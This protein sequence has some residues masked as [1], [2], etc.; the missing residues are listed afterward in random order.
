MPD[1]VGFGWAL[2]ALL[3]SGAVAGIVTATAL[4]VKIPNE[5]RGVCLGAFVVVAAVIGFGV[6]PTV[7]SFGST[8]LGGESHL[9]Q[10]LAITGV[11]IDVLSAL[12]FLF[13]MLDLARR[14]D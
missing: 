11:A 9:A 2:G 6:A 3:L 5:A 4:A 7:V 13:A 12:G 14:K 10:S 8:A 1:V